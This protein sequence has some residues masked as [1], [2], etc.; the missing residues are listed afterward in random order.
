MGILII[1]P[2]SVIYPQ[3]KSTRWTAEIKTNLYQNDRKKK[4][5]GE[6]L[7]QL[8]NHDPKHHLLNWSS[9]LA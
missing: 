5:S 2:R 8:M 1:V 4:K 6:G 9:A 3:N 7:E